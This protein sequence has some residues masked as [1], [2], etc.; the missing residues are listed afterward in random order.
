[1]NTIKR[2]NKTN[3]S[4]FFLFDPRGTGKSTWLK[5][6]YSDVLFIDLLDEKTFRTLSARPELL[7]NKISGTTKKQWLSMKF[8]EYLQSCQ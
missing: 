3:S 8:K 7:I 6:K 4:Y 5:Q 1:M 2:F